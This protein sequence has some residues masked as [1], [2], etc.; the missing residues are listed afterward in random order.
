MRRAQRRLSRRHKGS[1][2]RE[3]AQRQLATAHYRVANIRRDALHKATAT[4][5]QT[6]AK[7]AEQV[8]T[9]VVIEDLHVTG[10][11]KNRRLARAISDAGFGEFRRQL[12]YKAAQ[13]GIDIVVADR[14]YP[15]SKTFHACG[16]VNH[17]LT[18]DQREWECPTCGAALD[19]DLNAAQNLAALATNNV[20]S[21]RR[22]RNACG[23]SVSPGMTGQPSVKQESITML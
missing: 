21:V 19:R 12:T 18:L 17:D 8:P 11:V 16:A 6:K 22:E 13:R 1:K 10:M 9:V 20:P 5:V 15:S 2:N 23:D 14:F 3:K 7:S 4:L